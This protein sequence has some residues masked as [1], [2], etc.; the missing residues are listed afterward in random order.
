[1]TYN[2][3]LFL[4][5][6]TAKL[7]LMRFIISLFCS[8]ARPDLQASIDTTSGSHFTLHIEATNKMFMSIINLSV[9][10]SLAQVPNSNRLI[11]CCTYQVFSI[12]VELN[13]SHPIIM[14]SQSQNAMSRSNFENSYLLIS[15]TSGNVVLQVTSFYF[16]LLLLRSINRY[17][18]IWILFFRFLGLVIYDFTS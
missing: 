1:M 3:V 14:T 5:L 7:Y 15:R 4:Y 13:I 6:K 18:F 8:S 17:Q 12:W 16:L 2:F 10:S 11:I 9:A